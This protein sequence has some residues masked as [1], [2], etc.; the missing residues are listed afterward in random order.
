M[1]PTYLRPP[2]TSGDAL[3]FPESVNCLHIVSLTSQHFIKGL[4]LFPTVASPEARGWKLSCH[5]ERLSKGFRGSGKWKSLNRMSGLGLV[6]A[7][8]RGFQYECTGVKF[9][10]LLRNMSLQCGLTHKAIRLSNRE[11]KGRRAGTRYQ[12]RDF[13]IHA[14]K[15]IQHKEN[16]AKF[17]HCLH[18]TEE[19]M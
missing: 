3:S 1:A 5:W 16:T 19:E 2:L 6:A 11:D 13:T 14:H 17:Y 9:S 4:F 10:G 7:F 8:I 18:F 15:S 12:A